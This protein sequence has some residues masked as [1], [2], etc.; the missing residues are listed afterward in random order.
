MILLV[1][2]SVSISYSKEA[3]IVVS[4]DWWLQLLIPSSVSPT[5]SGGFLMLPTRPKMELTFHYSDADWISSPIFLL[6]P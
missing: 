1:R 4:E 5:L 6:D 3:W 2:R